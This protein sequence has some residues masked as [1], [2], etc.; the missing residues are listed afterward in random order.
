MTTV[1][2]SLFFDMP[3]QHFRKFRFPEWFTNTRSKTMFR[4]LFHDRIVSITAGHKNRNFHICFPDFFNSG[5]SA[6]SA[7]ASSERCR[8]DG[9]DSW[10]RLLYY[11]V[12]SFNCARIYTSGRSGVRLRPSINGPFG[13]DF[14][15][16]CADIIRYAI[17]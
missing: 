13:G 9:Q 4:R 12:L 8:R 5:F 15:S 3:L 1:H 6:L 17:A 10:R 7:H 11:S 2:W 14:N 16:G